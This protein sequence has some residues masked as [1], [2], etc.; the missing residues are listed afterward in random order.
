MSYPSHHIGLSMAAVWKSQCLMS[1]SGW[2]ELL[3]RDPVAVQAVEEKN[4]SRHRRIQASVRC[5]RRWWGKHKPWV[6]RHRAIGE[7]WKRQHRAKPKAEQ[8]TEKKQETRTFAEKS[9]TKRQGL[10]QGMRASWN[11]ARPQLERTPNAKVIF[12]VLRIVTLRSRLLS[13]YCKLI[14]P[15]VHWLL[16]SES[17]VCSAF[18]IELFRIRNSTICTNSNRAPRPPKD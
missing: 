13:L 12:A 18:F 3:P 5:S 16:S 7:R 10:I 11:G 15:K 14:K 9:T 2:T 17:T 1:E 4:P 6:H 8:T